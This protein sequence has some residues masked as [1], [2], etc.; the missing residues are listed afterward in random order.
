MKGDMNERKLERES[1][2]MR[3]VP[4][5]KGRRSWMAMVVPAQR[6]VCQKQRHSNW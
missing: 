5:F 2:A 3:V 4:D 1:Q 6:L